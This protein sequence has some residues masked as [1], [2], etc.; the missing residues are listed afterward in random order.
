MSRKRLN[1]YMELKLLQLGVISSGFV[2]SNGTFHIKHNHFDCCYEN[3]F[4]SAAL[5]F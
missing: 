2:T 3:I 5:N 4:T 1:C